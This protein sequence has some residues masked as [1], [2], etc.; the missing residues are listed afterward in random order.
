MDLSIKELARATDAALPDATKFHQHLLAAMK[1]F[2]ITTPRRASAFLAT[3]SIESAR[4]KKTEED[5]YYRD[6][7]RLAAIYPRAFKTAAEAAPFVCNAQAL[8]HKLY[9]GYWG[10]G[11]IQLTWV[12]NYAAAAKALGIDCVV[13]PALLT[14]PEHAAMSAAWFWSTAGCNAA[15]DKG[16]IAEVRRLV[17]G[18]A[19]L[20]L[21]EV[22]KLAATNMQWMETTA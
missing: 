16:D 3:V 21:A 2:S 18:P 4:L 12:S 20:H 14:Q 1:R 10:R 13:Q 19:R 7:A 15:A 6:A 8:G 9:A 11:L 22:T 5:L 17:N